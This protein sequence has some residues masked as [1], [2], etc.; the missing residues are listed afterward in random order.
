MFDF[1]DVPAH[2]AYDLV[3][4]IAGATGTA[5]AIV[6]FTAAVRLAL[7][8]LARSAIRGEKAR[9][10]LAP[11]A[12][13]LREKHKKNPERMQRELLALYQ[14]NGVSMFAGCLPMLLQIPVFMVLYRLFTA[15]SFD[16]TPN[17]LLSDV[18]FGAPLG[19]HF[20]SSG[21]DVVVFLGLF[22]ALLVVGYFASRAMPEETPK[23][24]RLLPFGTSFA[25]AVIP[26]AAGLYL[27][28][29]TTWTVLERA[30]L[31]R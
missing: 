17:N 14:D 23:F 15:G 26:L 28:T 27:L 9:A 8:P 21:A 11:Q 7:H 4:L 1:L 12:A 6:L 20:F 5:A 24:L 13:K 16:G 25:V 18:L 29:T 30:Y 31:R 22:A 10:A 2:G 3:S 19:S